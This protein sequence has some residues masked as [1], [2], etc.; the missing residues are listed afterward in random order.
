M[1][2][3]KEILKR[4]KIEADIV[5]VLVM[6]DLCC[7]VLFVYGSVKELKVDFSLLN[8]NTTLGEK[9]SQKESATLSC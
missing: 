4:L 7:D 6:V 1:S 9:E 3:I 2:I 5:M 8:Y